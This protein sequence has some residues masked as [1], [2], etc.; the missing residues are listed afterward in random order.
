MGYAESARQMPRRG[1]GEMVV[2]EITTEAV[3]GRRNQDSVR[4]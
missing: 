4:C 1:F 2:I 3:G